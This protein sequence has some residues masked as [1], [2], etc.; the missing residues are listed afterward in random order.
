M[1]LLKIAERVPRYASPGGRSGSA[2]GKAGGGT[3]ATAKRKTPPLLGALP[4]GLLLR[5]TAPVQDWRA[6]PSTEV[7][8][9]QT[10]MRLRS[11]WGTV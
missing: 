6:E 9:C 1:S 8:I 3:P 7:V 2:S 4:A 11:C 5:C 10:A